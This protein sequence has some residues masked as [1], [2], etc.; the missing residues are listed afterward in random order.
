MAEKLSDEDILA[1]VDEE[2][3]NSVGFYSGEL[4][5][6]RKKALEYYHG[7]PFGNE[8]E[9]RSTYVSREVLETLEWVMPP[10]MSIFYGG[11]SI[12]KC[13]PQNPDDV[14]KAKQAT[15]Y[16]NYIFQRQN[17][18]F[19][20]LYTFIKD[21]LLSKNGFLKIYYEEYTTPKTSTYDSLDDIQLS[22][23]I[24]RGGEVVAHSMNPDGTHAVS[25][26]KTEKSGKCC[27]KPVPPEEMFVNKGAKN[28]LHENRFVAHRRL[29]T[30]SELREMG[31][32]VP[33][34]F[35]GDEEADFNQERTARFSYDDTDE[36]PGGSTERR[37][38]LSDC[39][40]LLDVDGDGIAERR[41]IVTAGKVIFEN[42]ET[43]SVPFV[44]M[45]PIIMP[46]KLIGMSLADL[47]MDH[48]ELK[49]TV[50]RQILDNMYLANNGR[51][52]ALDGMVNI[53]DLLT[54]RPG[55]IVRVKTFDA[56]KP[57]QPPLLG[58]G[59]FGMLEYLDTVK[60]NRTGVTRYNQGVDADSLN[61][62]ATGISQIMSASQQRIQ[63]IAR[64]FAETGIKDLFYR[65]LECVQKHQKQPQVIQL[66]DEFVQMD[67]Q[68]WTNKFDMTVTVGLGTGSK[69][70]Q[71]AQ[72]FQLL[73]MQLTMIGGGLPNVT[74]QNI[75]N[76]CIKLLEA[77]N[78]KGGEMFFTDPS[79][80]PPQQQR[81]DPEMAKVAME[82]E[83]KEKELQLKAQEG[84]QK[85]KLDAE[86]AVMDV[87]KDVIVEQIR[88]KAQAGVKNMEMKAKSEADDKKRESDEDLKRTEIAANQATA[89][90]T[91]E[92][93][94]PNQVVQLLLAQLQQTS[95]KPKRRRGSF[96]GKA[97]EFVEAEGMKRGTF[98]GKPFEVYEE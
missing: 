55:G 21:A 18:G 76:T 20:T 39:Y 26:R 74:A 60:E 87:K 94:D 89:L 24:Q 51:Y 37:V 81:P 77:G 2:I 72:L 11:D 54:S 31:Y 47:V 19:L 17:D 7:E 57:M 80:I 27:V 29:V 38:W 97:F 13:E 42:E 45:T 62:T 93:A 41:R 3:R 86:K 22:Y 82:K 85:L 83:M 91:A 9:G 50:I 5:E 66:R 84:Q 73:Q 30:I 59:A 70:S 90:A 67:P 8:V 58:S 23:V 6:Q 12:V 52:M 1:K 44:T 56:V 49:S 63:L 16:L 61:K 96:N 28:P 34:D 33:D 46:H 98:N 10:M 32:D 79:K 65:I 78:I 43:D 35:M 64:V 14:Q 36:Q 25:I 68:E 92:G 69:E 95:G 75:Y 53:D 15:D 40:P 71:M 4:A 88:A 48:Q